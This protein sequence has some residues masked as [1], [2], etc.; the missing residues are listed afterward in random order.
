MLI[1]SVMVA[2]KFVDDETFNNQYYA[3][4][5][6]LQ[7]QELNHLERA[8]LNLIRFDLP[9]PHDLYDRYHNELGRHVQGDIDTCHKKAPAKAPVKS[10][11][12]AD[13]P[14]LPK[15][16]SCSSLSS[17][18][19]RPA[20]PTPVVQGTKNTVTVTVT[21][22]SSQTTK[23][24]IPES[25]DSHSK[26]QSGIDYT[27]RDMVPASDGSTTL[28]FGNLTVSGRPKNFQLCTPS[29]PNKPPHHMVAVSWG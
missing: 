5:G 27:A 19:T 28:D 6:G 7:V 11:P 9:V 25:K 23:I 20:Q 21:N 14:C 17:L 24:A 10:K 4:V 3:K 26:Y 29:Y 15:T 1:T 13:L 8:F 12:S 2:T 16:T 22:Q 18:N